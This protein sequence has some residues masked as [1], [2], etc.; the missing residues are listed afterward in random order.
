MLAE[1]NKVFKELHIEAGKYFC[2]CNSILDCFLNLLY[3][4]YT[5]FVNMMVSCGFRKY[6][7]NY[8]MTQ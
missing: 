1:E 2:S 7:K 4:Q 3:T 6:L 8:F 5:L